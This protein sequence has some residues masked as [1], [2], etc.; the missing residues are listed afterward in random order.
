MTT[1][2]QATGRPITGRTVLFSMLAFFGVIIAVNML[3]VY[4]ALDSWPG[5]STDEAYKD[6]LAYNKT[7]EAAALQG[8]LGWRS[9]VELVNGTQ[10]SA[11]LFN[12]NGDGVTV[13][14]V[15]ARLVRPTHAG[16]DQ[17]I[18]LKESQPGYYQGAVS[19]LLP[20]RWKVELRVTEGEQGRYFMVHELL[21]K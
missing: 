8:E 9:R 2:R 6:G 5:L 15:K 20:G 4:F 16:V 7:L 3:F 18:V 12:K 11:R 21:V 10:L 1:E 14:T 13:G 19:T 17:I